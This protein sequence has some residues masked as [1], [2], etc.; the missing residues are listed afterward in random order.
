MYSD[1]HQ[2]PF[3]STRN[4]LQNATLESPDVI[5]EILHNG[6][7]PAWITTSSQ[8]MFDELE[9]SWLQQSDTLFFDKYPLQTLQNMFRQGNSLRESFLYLQD[10]RTYSNDIDV[11]IFA[12]SD[13]ILLT[14]ID[15]NCSGI[16]DNEIWV[17]SWGGFM[18]INDRFAI[19]GPIAAK[20]YASRIEGY[21]EELLARRNSTKALHP[22]HNS[23]MLLRNWLNKNL[24][25]VTQM[26]EEWAKLSRVRADG[27]LDHS[28]NPSR[29]AT[30]LNVSK[31]MITEFNITAVGDALRRDPR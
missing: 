22:F 16:V 12:R 2:L 18:G 8:S 14:P 1:L 25:N 28:D 9:L 19:A 5:R 6:G 11:Y 10:Q 26:G 31:T 15:I 17:P 24:L 23:E 27:R 13:T 7:V 30:L 4:A 21:K 29:I 20:V 3:S